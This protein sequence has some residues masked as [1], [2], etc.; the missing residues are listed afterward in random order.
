MQLSVSV[1]PH[2]PE[3]QLLLLTTAGDHLTWVC[4]CGRKCV[5]VCARVCVFCTVSHYAFHDI[6]KRGNI[7]P[8]KSFSSLWL[9]LLASL[10]LF[11]LCCLHSDEE[12]NEGF[13]SAY[14]FLYKCV[15]V[16]VFDK[17]RKIQTGS[18]QLHIALKSCCHP[19]SHKILCEQLS[20]CHTFFL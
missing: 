20:H 2:T 7:S 14:L 3:M 16:G 11:C 1:N 15:W 10:K 17:E 18:Y 12:L 13:L 9:S 6:I 5:C 19:E 4:V 8:L